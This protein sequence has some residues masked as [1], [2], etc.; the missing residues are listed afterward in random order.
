VRVLGA[1]GT[2]IIS[3]HLVLALLRDGQGVIALN[4][5]RRPERVPARG[6]PR[7]AAIASARSSTWPNWRSQPLA[8]GLAHTYE[9]Y[10][11]EG[12]DRRAVDFTTE[13]AL[14]ELLRP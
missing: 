6:L 1:G 5:W 9:W 4:R 12:L 10:L 13:D 11:K 7:I 14:L 8:S 3:L 2:E